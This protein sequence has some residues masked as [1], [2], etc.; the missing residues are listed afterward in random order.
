MAGGNTTIFGVYPACD[1]AEQAIEILASAGFSK[2]R[3]SVLLPTTAVT[4]GCPFGEGLGSLP[5]LG[6][7][8]IA[9][10]DPFIAGGPMKGIL[11]NVGASE[12]EPGLVGALTGMG[13]PEYEARLGAELIEKGGVLLSLQCGSLAE[14]EA[15]KESLKASGAED[16]A[17]VTDILASSTETASDLSEVA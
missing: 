8:A 10:A 7:L 1:R 3:I 12:A 2:E 9:G 17:S 16:I 14:I 13:I 15:A 4:D 6:A 11:A 5:G